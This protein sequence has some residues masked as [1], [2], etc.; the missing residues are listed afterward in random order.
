MDSPEAKEVGANVG[1]PEALT[2]PVAV[3][4]YVQVAGA[5]GGTK[6]FPLHVCASRL[7][8]NN[9]PIRFKTK[10]NVDFIT[11]IIWLR[12]LVIHYMWKSNTTNE[13]LRGVSLIKQAK[14]MAYYEL[15]A[16]Y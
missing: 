3:Y 13:Y 4:E 9:N 2:Q 10:F 12:P 15:I 5:V 1:S 14:F 8:T 11:F 7:K 6:V 16:Q